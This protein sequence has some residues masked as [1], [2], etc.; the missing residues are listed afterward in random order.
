MAAADPERG[1]GLRAIVADLHAN[2]PALL[3]CL[4]DLDAVEAERRR[5]IEAIWCLGDIAGYGPHLSAVLL[6]IV[7]SRRPWRAIRGNHDDALLM[8]YDA[9]QRLAALPARASA[10]RAIR[11]QAIEVSPAHR[12]V[13]WLRRLP[14]ILDVADGVCLVHPNDGRHGIHA[15]S[16]PDETPLSVEWEHAALRAADAPP[17]R[18][19]L[20]GHTH[21]PVA[22]VHGPSGWQRH[23]PVGVV[24]LDG[25]MAWI[26]PGSVGESRVIGDP[27]AH[28]AIHDIDADTIEFRR[29]A[30]D[31]GAVRMAS[32]PHY[33]ILPAWAA[34]TGRGP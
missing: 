32:R 4:R 18:L 6:A 2:L 19:V 25:R 10:I 33:E 13:E 17:R 34:P 24:S 29:V 15:G 1:S 30:Y 5:P 16:E 14:A 9:P 28:Y 27:R 26:N 11:R 22:F 21:V 20:R 7:G 8:A 3:A 31:V 12:G 23:P